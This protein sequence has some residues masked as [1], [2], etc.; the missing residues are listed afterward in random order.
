MSA[1]SSS[2]TPHKKVTSNDDLVIINEAN[3]NDHF[4]L[5]VAKLAKT[6]YTVVAGMHVSK[7]FSIDPRP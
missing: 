7:P 6:R 2:K 3:Q 5:V 1:I 4:A